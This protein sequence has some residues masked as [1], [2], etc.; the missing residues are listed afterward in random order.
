MQITLF[1]LKRGDDNDDVN[2]PRD[3]PTEEVVKQLSSRFGVEMAFI[4]KRIESL[5]ERDYLKR[6]DQNRWVKGGGLFCCLF[7]VCNNIVLCNAHGALLPI[8]EF[9]ITL[10]EATYEPGFFACT[11]IWFTKAQNSDPKR[12]A[13]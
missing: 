5:I 6:D 12:E 13:Y 1:T 2:H 9:T 11:I 3:P 10:P 8:G 7:F 4:K